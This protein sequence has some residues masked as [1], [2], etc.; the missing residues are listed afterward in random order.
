MGSCLQDGWH[1]GAKCLHFRLF[2]NPLHECGN[3]SQG[4]AAH[5]LA[6]VPQAGVCHLHQGAEMLPHVLT[7]V[8]HGRITEVFMMQAIIAATGNIAC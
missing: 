3:G 1:Q 7:Y 2:S 4:L 8:T 5:A 6:G